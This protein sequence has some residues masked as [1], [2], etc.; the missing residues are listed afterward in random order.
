MERISKSEIKGSVGTITR[1]R[2]RKQNLLK[3]ILLWAALTGAFSLAGLG[4]AS[5]QEGLQIGGI[6]STGDI[7][8]VFESVECLYSTEGGTA[9]ASIA[10]DRKAIVISVEG[11]YPGYA[12]AFA[13]EVANRGTVPVAFSTA[14]ESSSAGITVVN[15][16]P[17][18]I[19]GGYLGSIPGELWIEVGEEV[20]E[21]TSY[22]FSLK[23]L[24]R[25][26][27]A[28]P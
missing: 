7:D 20:E 3:G 14:V 11:A 1:K 16:L 15:S 28:A 5:W 25:Q 2:S 6:V 23:L 8:P 19:L 10:G 17:N 26:W 21:D 22:A 24:F 13:Y 4:L 9:S 27:N 12:A 18:G